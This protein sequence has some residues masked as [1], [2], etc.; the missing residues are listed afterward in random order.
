M[1]TRVLF[2]VGLSVALLALTGCI[3]SRVIVESIPTQ[4]TLKW[5]GVERGETPIEI[6]LLWYWFHDIELS[7]EGYGTFKK[8]ERF[9]T[10]PWL[11]FP[12]DGI[13]EILPIP[14]SDT[15]YRLYELQPLGKRPDNL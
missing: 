13:A 10:P 7:K 9:R 6:P 15:R 11:I 5:D 3:K 4:A 1:R 14:I 2:T 12:I 8:S